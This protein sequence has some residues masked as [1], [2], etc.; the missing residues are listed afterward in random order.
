MA[1]KASLW[2]RRV[3]SS[4]GKSAKWVPWPHSCEDTWLSMTAQFPY[5]D[6]I[7]NRCVWWI[8]P[9][10]ST[11]SLNNGILIC[12][13]MISLLPVCS[14][15]YIY[16]RGYWFHCIYFPDERVINCTN[17]ILVLNAIYRHSHAVHVLSN[18]WMMMRF[19]QVRLLA[20]HIS[21]AQCRVFL[22]MNARFSENIYPRAC[23]DEYDCW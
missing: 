17:I 14:Y 2:D 1:Q 4:T 21:D 18:K 22:L 13:Y 11:H 19:F 9:F 10:V 20:S 3:V 7:C 12:L 23:M 15:I 5:P 16:Y 6:C 8:G